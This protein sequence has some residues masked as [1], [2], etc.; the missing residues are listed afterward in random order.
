MDIEYPGF[1]TIVVDGTRYDHDIVIDRGEIKE[2]DKA[3]SR[4][5]PDRFGHTPLSAREDLPWH[6]PRLLI[7]SGFSGSLP[8][9]DDV[10]AAAEQSGVELVIA[11]TAEICALVRGTA[12]AEVN[13]VLH[14]TC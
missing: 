10:R 2:R 7:G 3:L 4:T 13:A 14:V 8:I 6:G 12:A 1:G 5:H 11:P 9:L